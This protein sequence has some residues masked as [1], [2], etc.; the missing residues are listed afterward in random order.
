VDDSAEETS[1]SLH[2]GLDSR[3]F[4]TK[5]LLQRPLEEI[6][7]RDLGSE[8]PKQGRLETEQQCAAILCAE[9]PANQKQI[10]HSSNTGIQHSCNP[11]NSV[12]NPQ[13]IKEK[14]LYQKP[15]AAETATHVP[16][17]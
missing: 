1:A 10:T 9:L 17:P 14:E 13:A 7:C 6:H 16:P 8:P 11:K 2:C 4:T 15:D 12:R 5:L 3:M